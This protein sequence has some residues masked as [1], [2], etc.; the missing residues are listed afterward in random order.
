MIDPKGAYVKITGDP[1]VRSVT[2]KAKKGLKDPNHVDLLAKFELPS[3]F[4]FQ[5]L[6]A[7]KGTLALQDQD[8]DNRMS[9]YVYNE[10]TNK[11]TRYC[12]IILAQVYHDLVTAVEMPFNQPV[13][14]QNTGLKSSDE[15]NEIL[16][17]AQL[18]VIPRVIRKVEQSP[19]QAME[20]PRIITPHRVRGYKR[21]G[22]LSEE[23]KKRLQEFEAETGFQILKWLPEGYTFV[24]PHISPAQD[25]DRIKQYPQFIRYRIQEEIKQVLSKGDPGEI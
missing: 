1:F 9:R 13:S 6:E 12:L 18:T 24:R 3:G 2:I 7:N 21:S 15:E 17:Q 14:V 8:F 22:N 4:D 20:H 19:R 25:S 5:V 10:E 23:H 16:A 11:T